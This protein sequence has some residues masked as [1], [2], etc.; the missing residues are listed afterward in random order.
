MYFKV[1]LLFWHYKVHLSV[2]RNI[3]MKVNSLFSALK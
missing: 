1:K 3:V 2:L